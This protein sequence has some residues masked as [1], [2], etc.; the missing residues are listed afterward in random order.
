MAKNAEDRR[1]RSQLKDTLWPFL[2]MGCKDLSEAVN[3]VDIVKMG[4]EGAWLQKK[5]K[6]TLNSLDIE[7]TANK[8]IDDWKKVKFLLDTLK[9]ETVQG[10]INILTS[11][12]NLINDYGAKEI[13]KQPMKVLKS[14]FDEEFK[15]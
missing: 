4:I 9:Y 11:L 15:G 2:E 8:T 13:S 1:L 7:K 10:S 5:N 3:L 14:Y 12:K 6:A